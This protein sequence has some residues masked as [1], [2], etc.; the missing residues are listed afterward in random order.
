MRSTLPPS[1]NPPA[2]FQL[3]FAAGGA[4]IAAAIECV[5]FNA[6]KMPED[7]SNLRGNNVSA[8]ASHILYALESALH[9]TA[10]ARALMGE[11]VDE[12]TIFTV[13]DKEL[14]MAGVN[15]REAQGRT[16]DEYKE[17]DTA[18]IGSNQI[19]TTQSHKAGKDL[20]A[21][22]YSRDLA[23]FVPPVAQR[24]QKIRQV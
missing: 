2:A 24:P 5:G 15:V 6:E 23:V 20:S 14:A 19:R 11:I 8:G 10:I 16:G 3:F 12:E 18:A 22:T 17:I 9:H 1:L 7:S 21:S 13:T 4:G